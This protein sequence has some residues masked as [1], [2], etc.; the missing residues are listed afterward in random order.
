M[1]VIKGED[2]G[3]RTIGK[4]AQMTGLP[5]KAFVLHHTVTNATDSPVA[6]ARHV[7][8]VGIARFGRLSYSELAHPSGVWLRGQDTARGAHTVDEHT[9]PLT[10]HNND[11]FG[12]ASIGDFTKDQVT[13]ALLNTIAGII[14]WHVEQGDMIENYEI[15]SHDQFK[16]TLC[17][18]SLR[19]YIPQI[20]RRVEHVS[21]PP[22]DPPG[23]KL[24]ELTEFEYQAMMKKLSLHTA[25]LQRQHEIDKVF[26]ERLAT[27]EQRMDDIVEDTFST[28]D[29]AEL[30][31]LVEVHEDRWRA[32]R[33]SLQ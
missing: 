20:K 8:D 29:I 19:G 15:L 10:S 21:S 7:E 32:L 28:A 6:D 5:A 22:P 26:E 3:A 24:H 4:K 13:D 11:M 23:P 17:P 14:V 12:I 9:S 16:A 30:D 25:R 33:D 1:K 31:A 18:G 2:W 27:L